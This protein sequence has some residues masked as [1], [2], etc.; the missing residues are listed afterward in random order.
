MA[1][2]IT[3]NDEIYATEEL[4]IEKT[5]PSMYRPSDPVVGICRSV[6]QGF[7]AHGTD[8]HGNTRTGSCAGS[9]A[10]TGTSAGPCARTGTSTGSRASTGPRAGPEHLELADH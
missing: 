5:E 1:A 6:R 10:R 3:K 7:A 4:A 8:P 2:D 9:R